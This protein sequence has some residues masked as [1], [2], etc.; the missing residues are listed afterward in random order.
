MEQSICKGARRLES[1]YFSPVRQVMERVAEVKAAGHSV[2][3]FSAGEP[4]FN[5][6]ELIKQKTIEAI[7]K[8]ETHYAP[9]RGT[10]ALRTEIA[11]F[12]RHNFGLDYDPATEILLT[13]GG[14]EAVNVVFMAMVDPGDEVIVF[15]PAFMNYENV[16]AEAGGK[17]IAVPLRKEDGFQINPETLE[18][19]ITSRTK[20]VVI[21]NPCNPTGIVYSRQVLEQVAQ[22]CKKHNLI[23]LSDEIYNKIVYNGVECCSVATLPGMRERT[24]TMNGF[25]KAYA[26][27]GWRMGYLA[28][29]AE[30]TSNLLKI[31]QYTTTCISTFSQIGVEQAMNAPE[32]LAEVDAMVGAFSCRRTL[33]MSGLDQIPGLSYIVPEG[34]FYIF[35]DVS[36]T[37]MD[38]DAFAARLL[39]SQYVGCVPGSK[40]G[41]ES[42]NFIRISYATSEA[43]IEEGLRRIA[44]FVSE[45]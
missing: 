22:V 43:N 42:G 29:P 16:I 7:L 24:V 31:H 36:G 20:M 44:K 39:E 45:L 23:V 17:M 30:M 14:A 8:N 25:S 4:D 21:N 33:L 26:M 9:N 2:I 5:T 15:T 12:L 37:G 38:G 32:T 13:C 41:K 3:S 34:A 10:L 35:V 28:A 27:T 19:H 6:P 1:M 11:K 18:A 40:L